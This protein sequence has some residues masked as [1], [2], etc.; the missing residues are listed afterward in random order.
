VCHAVRALGVKWTLVALSRDEP[1]G[2]A[3]GSRYTMPVNQSFGHMDVSA[4]RVIGISPPVDRLPGSMAILGG[5]AADAA[6]A[7]S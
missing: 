3:T 7:P 6:K 4:L 5:N 2:T 1:D